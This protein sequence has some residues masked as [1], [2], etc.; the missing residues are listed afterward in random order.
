MRTFNHIRDNHFPHGYSES[1]QI[2][3]EDL[4]TWY[5]KKTS[6]RFN[7]E[8]IQTIFDIGSLNGIESVKFTEKIE[9]CSVHTFEPNPYSYKNVLISTEGIERIK[10]HNIAMSNFSGK[11]G[12]YITHHNMGASSLL[13]PTGLSL[14]TG[15]HIDKI[16]VDVH[17]LDEWCPAN[18]ISKID[19]IWM[20][21]QGS[22]LN[23]F[24]GMG[25]LL[26]DVKSIYVESAI[27]PYYH[28]ASVKDDVVNYLKNYNLELVSETYHDSYEGDFMFLKSV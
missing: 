23:I 1:I 21:A 11:S 6:E 17:R 26:K 28:G 22:E 24:K 3:I 8:D 7:L 14:K 15:T 20:D 12:F 18:N 5:L 2:A 4:V 9:N 25:D 27:I 16:E 13:E 19:M 10:V